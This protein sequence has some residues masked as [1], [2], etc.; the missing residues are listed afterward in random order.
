MGFKDHF[1][2]HA[3]TYQ[4]YRPGYPQELFAWLAEQTPQHLRAWDCA[5]GNGQAARGLAPYYRE[6]IATDASDAQIANAEPLAGVQYRVAT[7]E[8]S[9]LAANS[10]DLITVGQAYHWFDHTAF[11]REAKRVLRPGGVLAIWTYHLFRTPRPELDAVIQHY[12]RDIVGSY[13]PPEREWVDKGYRDMPFPFAELQVPDFRIKL[14]WTLEQ[15]LGYL[16]SWSATQAYIKARGDDPLLSL[17]HELQQHWPDSP[18]MPITWPMAVRAGR[19][20]E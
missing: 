5:T 20:I 19:H 14:E 11:H 8:A 4:A 1:S 2:G 12:Y 18:S 16:R 3:K 10:V 13:W 7:A 9:G 15:V 6:V 17:A